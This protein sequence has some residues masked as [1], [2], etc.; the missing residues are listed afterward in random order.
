M[1]IN[2]ND[3]QDCENLVPDITGFVICGWKC[4]VTGL[5]KCNSLTELEV[6][7]DD[8]PNFKYQE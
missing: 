4:K 2:K 6:F 1:S 7:E 3:C 5:N 8:C